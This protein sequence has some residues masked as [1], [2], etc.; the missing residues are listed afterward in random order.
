MF[1]ISGIAQFMADG[2]K[3][4]SLQAARDPTIYP[5]GALYAGDLD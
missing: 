4:L 2:M 1:R 5:R 3:G